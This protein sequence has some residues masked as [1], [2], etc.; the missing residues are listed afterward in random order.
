MKINKSY[1]PF[2]IPSCVATLLKIP[3]FDK[4]ITPVDKGH[5]LYLGIQCLLGLPESVAKLGKIQGQFGIDGYSGSESRSTSAWPIIMH[6]VGSNIKPFPISN[7]VGRK[8][9]KDL[10]KFLESFAN[11]IQLLEKDGVFV[12]KKRIKFPFSLHSIVTDTNGRSFV[13]GTRDHLF[14]S[15]DGHRCDQVS[16]TQYRRAVFKAEIGNKRTDKSF[17]DRE[18]PEHHNLKNNTILTRTVLE[19]IGIGMI[20]PCKARGVDQPLRVL[21]LRRDL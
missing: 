12:S 5:A 20:P 14:R 16:T 11:G 13:S 19:E 6:I 18:H 3:K 21:N 8:S 17:Y 9:P 1:L 10:N 15:A 7:Y 2:H 4:I